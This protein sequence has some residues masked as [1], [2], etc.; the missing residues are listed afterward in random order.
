M[1]CL[2]LF[3]GFYTSKNEYNILEIVG[4]YFYILISFYPMFK[5]LVRAVLVA[6]RPVGLRHIFSHGL[7]LIIMKTV[8]L[9][10]RKTLCISGTVDLAG[11][12]AL[13]MIIIFICTFLRKSIITVLKTVTISSLQNFKW[14]IHILSNLFFYIYNSY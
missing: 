3:P 7:E 2:L 10:C 5:I 12:S 6:A 13:L 1:Y 9:K 11:W 4:S 14:F 8:Y